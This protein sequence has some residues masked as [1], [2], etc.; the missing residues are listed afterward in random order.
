MLQN[1]PYTP[2]I[3]ISQQKSMFGFQSR[4]LEAA[5]G[6]H[7]K[8]GTTDFDAEKKFSVKGRL[9]GKKKSH[10]AIC[11]R[12]SADLGYPVFRLVTCIERGN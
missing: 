11:D 5:F 9:E 10:A 8:S 2:N 6:L 12:E 3:A 7:R 1:G 4:S